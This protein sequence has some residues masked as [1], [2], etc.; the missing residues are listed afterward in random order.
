MP[1]MK[2]IIASRKNTVFS[3]YASTPGA[4]HMNLKN[5]TA[6]RKNNGPSKENAL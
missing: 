6:E 5:A 3:N 4:E 1:N 2:S